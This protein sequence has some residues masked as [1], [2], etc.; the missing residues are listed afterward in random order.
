MDKMH[1]IKEDTLIDGRNSP[2]GTAHRFQT[3]KPFYGDHLDTS[4]LSGEVRV[5]LKALNVNHIM[6]VGITSEENNIWIY[7]ENTLKI[8]IKKAKVV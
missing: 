7:Q 2:L 8:E 3:C 5:K 4:E 6:F 1:L